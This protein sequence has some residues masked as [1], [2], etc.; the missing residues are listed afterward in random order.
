MISYLS[1]E[2]AENK[3]TE[4]LVNYFKSINK[5]M[6]C[7][8]DP[9]HVAEILWNTDS[10]F[11]KKGTLDKEIIAFA[12]IGENKIFIEESGYEPRDRFSIAHEVGHISLHTYLV[13]L[14][15]RRS[16]EDK[17][18]EYQSDTYASALL[19][20]KEMILK[21]INENKEKNSFVDDEC[22]INL[23]KNKFN[24]SKQSARIRLENMNLV[25]NPNIKKEFEKYDKN[26][27]GKREGWINER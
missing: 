17:Y 3:A 23:V 11:F 7:Y 21:V 19:M 25:L 9:V 5:N 16:I 13:N 4:D 18:Y 14:N 15:E 22:R 26:Q 20:P 8:I 1:K 6:T 24:V 10:V 27:Q 2:F 12:D